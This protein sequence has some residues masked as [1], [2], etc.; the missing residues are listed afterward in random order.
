M[1][2]LPARAERRGPFAALPTDIALA[3]LAVYIVWGSTYLAIRIGLESIPPLLLI[4]ARYLAAGAILY[5][6]LWWR[7]GRGADY[8]APT[9]RQWLHSAV[10]GLVMLGGGTGFTALAEQH[11]PSSLSATIVTVSPILASVIA[12]AFGEQPRRGE[13]LGVGVGFAGAF[14][15]TFD[16]NARASPQGVALQLCSSL[17][18]TFGSMV[19]KYRLHLPTGAM[20]SASQMLA[21]GALII[22]IGL[23]RG[24]GLTRP[25][26]AES[27][28]AWVYLVVFG[29]ILGY[30][31]YVHLLK[32]TRPALATSYAYVNPIVAVL[33]GMTLAGERVS[34]FQVAAMAV[35][36]AGVAFI[37]RA[38]RG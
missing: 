31:A 37:A 20:T 30:S 3:L 35:I 23:V 21:G 19:A 5:G 9:R 29:S 18:W 22:L 17:T 25:V 14:L 38:R 11:I 12:G 36:L 34:V 24:E 16:P 27:A 28:W 2:P 1:K 6:F 15:L 13:W 10:A 26:L 7:G 8:V 33:L 32:N 4:G